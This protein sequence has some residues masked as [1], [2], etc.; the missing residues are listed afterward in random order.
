MSEFPLKNDFKK[1][2]WPFMIPAEWLNIVANVLNSL[3]VVGGTL[4]REPTGRGWTL[5]CFGGTG[6]FSGNVYVNG[7]K[8]T[9][10]LDD[11]LPF[12]KVSLN[13][14]GGANVVFSEGPM[15]APFPDG[16]EWY[17]MAH[18]FGDIHIPMF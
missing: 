1:G 7:V 10:N 5:N 15:P 3:R 2:D 8:Y 6:A 9:L 18:T 4:A 17:E 12:V 13:P 14:T 16:E 11:I